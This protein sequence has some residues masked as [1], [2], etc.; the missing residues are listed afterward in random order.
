[1]PI[2]APLVLLQ[3]AFEAAVNAALPAQVLPRHLPPHPEGRL[4]VVGA[5]KAAA[6]MAQVIEGHYNS[7]LEGVVITRYGH[8]LP[9]DT[10]QVIEA[11]HPVPDEAG[12][13]ATAKLIGSLVGLCEQ[14]LV[15]CLV[16][17]GGSALLVAPA[18]ITLKEKAELTRSLLNCGADIHEMNCVRKH[19]SLIKGGRLAEVAYPTKVIT[20]AISDVVGDNA[21]V[22]ASGPTVPDPSTYAEAV[23]ILDRYGVEAPGARAQLKRGALGEIM[24]TPKPGDCTFNRVETRVVA[25]NQIS[26]EA[27]AASLRAS[28]IEAHILSANITGE[29]RLA[30]ANQALIVRQIIESS[31]PFRAP[32]ALLS[33]GE[34]TVTVRGYGRGGR[35]AE[36]A[37]GLA[38]ELPHGVPVYALAADSDGI[39]GS[40]DN[41]GAFITPDLFRVVP[42]QR[43]RRLLSLN[44][45]YAVFNEAEHLFFTG[46]THTNVNDLRIVLILDD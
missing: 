6:A 30:G 27:A 32:C 23:A 21:S 8:S 14:D 4:V 29:A 22:I 34:T 31:R 9:T 1:V 10:I 3:K 33:G 36:F 16:S 37:L 7:P 26:L 38:L 45:S 12:E 25:T 24:E 15:L 17:G 13:S 40:E 43:A 5:G 28:G 19:L 44:D 41:A 18:G 39:D 11:G 2:D 46:P 20:L 42:Y 35:N